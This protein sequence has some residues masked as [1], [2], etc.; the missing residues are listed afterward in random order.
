MLIPMDNKEKLKGDLGEEA[1]NT[2]AFKT[3]LK[4]WCYPGPRLGLL[5]VA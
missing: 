1:V 3:Y 2:L 4:Y 5:L